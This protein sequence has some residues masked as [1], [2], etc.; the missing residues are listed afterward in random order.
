MAFDPYSLILADLLRLLANLASKFHPRRALGLFKQKGWNDL[1]LN[2]DHLSRMYVH[3]YIYIY[4]LYIYNTYIH[5][6]YKCGDL[7]MLESSQK[8]TQWMTQRNH[9]WGYLGQSWLITVTYV[10]KKSSECAMSS[11]NYITQTSP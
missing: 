8:T 6:I 7:K 5:N 2:S 3:I 9:Y 1:F 10:K 4:I 11:W